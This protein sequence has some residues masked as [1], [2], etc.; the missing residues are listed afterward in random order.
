M[1]SATV[2]VL[3]DV[4]GVR[5]AVSLAVL[6]RGVVHLAMRSRYNA[7]KDICWV[8]R[9]SHLRPMERLSW[10]LVKGMVQRRMAG[11]AEAFETSLLHS[12]VKMRTLR[13]KYMAPNGSPE[14]V[15][16]DI[17]VLKAARGDEL[18]VLVVKYEVTR[19]ALF[20]LFDMERIFSRYWIVLEMSWSGSCHHSLMCFVGRGRRV[21]VQAPE[22][23][24]IRFLRY[25]ES[26]LQCIELGTGDWIDTGWS[27]HGEEKHYDI[28]MVASWAP[29]KN[30]R[31]LFRALKSVSMPLRVLLIGFPAGNRTKEHIVRQFSRCL[32]KHGARFDLTV[33][34]DIP[35]DDVL[36]YTAQSKVAVLL[37]RK[38][39][40]NKAIMEAMVC[41]V[42]AIVYEG[43]SGGAQCRIDSS[44]GILSSFRELP[45]AIEYMVQ[46]HARFSPRRT[47]LETTGSRLSTR[48]LNALLKAS[49]L[50]GG[51][52][53]RTDIVEKVNNP[54]LGY[55]NPA[56]RERFSKDYEFLHSALRPGESR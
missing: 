9:V 3:F 22:V 54:N 29:Y 17:L 28:V 45:R 53:W 37:S 47:V 11:C 49:T 31:L 50:A 48:K 2:K 36:R 27:R 13:R 16:R 44:T 25:L 19:E 33:L 34:E 43:H 26:N 10:W 7:L 55:R 4:W 38:E 52:V 24:D 41:D 14:R 39:G 51:E 12:A 6:I 18:G 8:G 35:H 30:H 40:F 15:F 32:G 5:C 1:P 56:D 21:V 23:D 42:P 20:L 46:N